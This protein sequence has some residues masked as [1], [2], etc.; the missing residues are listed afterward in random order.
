M[1]R[2]T[3][4]PYFLSHAKKTIMQEVQVSTQLPDGWLSSSF[5]MSI[6][7]LSL[8]ACG[9]GG[10]GSLAPPDPTPIPAPTPIPDPPVPTPEP[11]PA[12]SAWLNPM[13]ITLNTENVRVGVVDTG[14]LVEHFEI[15]DRVVAAERF[16]GTGTIEDDK[17]P[18]GTAVAMLIAGQY[19]GFS[20][21]ADLVLAKVADRKA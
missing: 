8:A 9:G 18:H 6:I 3:Q 5:L 20:G 14:F 4:K 10:G 7:A 15:K 2:I 17:T 12:P 13:R 1:V 21:N 11:A 16:A 19:V